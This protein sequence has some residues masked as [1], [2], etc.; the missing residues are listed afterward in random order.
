MSTNYGWGDLRHNIVIALLGKKRF[1]AG[2]AA[3]AKLA[4]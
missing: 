1:P 3:G 4:A 2:Q